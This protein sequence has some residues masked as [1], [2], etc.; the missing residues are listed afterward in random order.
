MLE[1]KDI[2]VFIFP[3]DVFIDVVLPTTTEDAYFL[4]DDIYSIM[5]KKGNEKGSVLVDLFLRNG[6]SF[7]RYFLLSF[8]GKDKYKTNIINP[9]LVSDN[10]KNSIKSFL[11][12][13]PSILERSS[14]SKKTLE[15]MSAK[16]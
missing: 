15:F 1:M 9:R 8:N 13:H 2:E 3:D 5:S 12:E 14:L 11:L 6:Y 7:N 10:I 4:Y 16:R